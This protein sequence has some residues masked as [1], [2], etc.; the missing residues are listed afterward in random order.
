MLHPIH[1]IDLLYYK[2]M[3]AYLNNK[4]NVNKEEDQELSPQ[5]V[6]SFVERAFAFVEEVYNSNNTF[7]LDG[8][9][10]VIAETG[11]VGELVDYVEIEIAKLREKAL[12]AGWDPRIKIKVT[13]RRIASAQQILMYSMD[14][15]A[16]HQAMTE[17]PVVEVYDSAFTDKDIIDNPSV[18]QINDWFDRELQSKKATKDT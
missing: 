9:Q 8:L 15:D 4:A 2:K 17:E 7:H 11:F 13:E 14:L 12:H 5:F 16:T 18:D 1:T 3:F 6:M 10:Q